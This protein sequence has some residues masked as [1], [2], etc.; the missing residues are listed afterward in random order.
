MGTWS[1]QTILGEGRYHLRGKYYPG[2]IYF[3]ISG[4]P[5][6]DHTATQPAG[7]G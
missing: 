4:L 6:W 1:S 5:Q 7:L 2:P 3:A